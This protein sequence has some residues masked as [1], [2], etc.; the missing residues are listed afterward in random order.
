MAIWILIISVADILQKTGIYTRLFKTHT[1]QS[2]L[3]SI[4]FSGDLSL[5][6]SAKVAGWTNVKMFEKF[7]KKPVMDNNSGN[8]L[9]NNS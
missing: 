8:F 7:H 5:T 2:E 3:I 4:S 9:L 1:F 6:E